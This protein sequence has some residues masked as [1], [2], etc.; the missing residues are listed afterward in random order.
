MIILIITIQ[1]NIAC[2]WSAC[3]PDWRAE[4]LAG[5]VISYWVVYSII[6]G[7]YNS[8]TNP[9]WR[10]ERRRR[11]RGR[12]HP[13][14]SYRGQDEQGFKGFICAYSFKLFYRCFESCLFSQHDRGPG[15][16]GRPP[17]GAP[18]A[19][20]RS[21]GP[22]SVSQTTSVGL[23]QADGGGRRIS[24]QRAR[25]TASGSTWCVCVHGYVL[26]VQHSADMSREWLGETGGAVLP[27]D[28]AGSKRMGTA[29]ARGGRMDRILET[30]LSWLVY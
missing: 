9:Y 22:T 7:H 14:S 13:G 18:R 1:Y 29:V 25:R 27:R 8:L 2:V 3:H 16:P 26:W 5:I 28:L 6:K 23:T 11:Q 4:R 12:G 15:V 20:G 21:R 30:P 24:T 19:K 17:P 10:A